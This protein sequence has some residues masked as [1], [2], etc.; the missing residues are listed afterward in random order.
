MTF[1]QGN[2]CFASSNEMSEVE[3]PSLQHLLLITSI[4]FS[5]DKLPF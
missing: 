2:L 3:K 5:E 4:L 1:I